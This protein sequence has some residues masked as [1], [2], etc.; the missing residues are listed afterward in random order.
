MNQIN[1]IN[2][3][4][5]QDTARDALLSH[6]MR[7]G[8]YGH[9]WTPDGEPYVNKNGRTVTPKFTQW[10]DAG[11]PRPPVP[12]WLEKN[13]YWGVHPCTCKG[14]DPTIKPNKQRSSVAIIAAINCFF[15]EFDGKDYVQPDEY[16]P[17]LPADF[18]KLM[19]NAAADAVDRMLGL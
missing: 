5:D 7:G 12:S 11:R 9:Y 10:F 15:S 4:I 3:D 19:V 1:T 18:G 8:V 17:Y 14:I 16:A 13:L 6:L 2:I